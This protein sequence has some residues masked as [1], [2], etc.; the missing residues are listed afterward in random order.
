M[1]RLLSLLLLLALLALPGL[2]AHAQ[3]ADDSAMD[4]DEPDAVGMKA[5]Q[6]R[7]L[8]AQPLPDALPERYALLQQQVRAAEALDQRERQIAVLTELARLG[9]GMPGGETWVRSYLSAEFTWGSQ[10]K[11]LAACE[12]LLADKRISAPM[13]A[14]IAL[15]QTY[16]AALGSDRALMQ[17]HWS[18]ADRLSREQIKQLGADSVAGLRLQIERLQVQSEV[19]RWGGAQANSVALLRESVRVSERLLAGAKGNDEKFYAQKLLD[20]SLGML[21]YALV[22][23]GRSPEAVAIA[24]SNIAL[25]RSGQLSDAVGARW[26]YRLATGLV[27]TQAFDE[28]LKAARES[29]EMLERSGASLTSH[30]RWLARQQMLNALLG[31]HQ[32]AEADAL[33]QQTLAAVQDDSL[34]RE[35]ASDWRLRALLA[36]K[37]GRVDEA[38]E[39]VERIH[40]F[41]LR[42]YGANHPQTQEAAGVRGFV[43]L[44]RNDISGAMSDYEQLFKALLDSPGG[45]LDLDL[46][47]VRG[48]VLGLAL[49]QF[50]DTLAERSLAGQPVDPRM[51][52]RALQ[53]ADRLNVSSTQRALADST[54]RLLA[55]TPA[56]AELLANE[57]Q[58]RRQQGER[59]SELSSLLNEE[60]RQRREMGSDAF[61]AL[62]PKERDAA[63]AALKALREKIKSGQE[64][65]GNARSA[66]TAARERI[67]QAF[68]AYGDLLM[69]PT[70]TPAQLRSLLAPDE[71]LLLVHSLDHATLLWL[72]TPGQQQAALYVSKLGA[73]DLAKRVSQ[74]RRML[75]L[76]QPGAPKLNEALLL[77]LY[78]ELIAPLKPDYSQLHSLIVASSGALASLPLAALVTEPATGKEGAHYL[79]R[80]VA[81]TQ[82]PAASA[83]QSLRRGA[84]HIGAKPLI[85]FGDPAFRSAAASKGLSVTSTRYDAAWGFRYADIPPLPDTRTELMAL[86]QALGAKPADLLLGPAAT[87]EAVLK[88]PLADYRV[89]AFA[90]HGLMPGELPGVS[91]PALAMAATGREGESPLLELDDVLGLRLN[92]EWVLLSAC[93]TAAGEQGGAAM[94]GLVRGFFFAGARSVLA[95]HWSVDSAASSQLVPAALQPSKARAESLRQAQLAMI[96]GRVGQGRWTHPYYWAGYALFGDPLK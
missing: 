18:R 83:L 48:F 23:Q 35:R 76:S 29:D 80:S 16:F 15:R 31:L 64:Q 65:V 13:R 60:D 81:V 21:C 1:R 7:A 51:A 88:A 72:I 90:T 37:N 49:Q 19:E 4:A 39:T 46:R 52:D 58:L 62:P 77:G 67:A 17:G 68:P 44:M 92:A 28:G 87:R 40:R 74:T 57:Q 6:A 82:L 10:G 94:S 53:L 33:Y 25:W 24:Q 93:N 43:R 41:R 8:L 11:A 27:A 26:Q 95:T 96:E 30:T 56:L 20:G 12:T 75:D 71:G 63:R 3:S 36:A 61:K 34:A 5:E 78:R 38:L 91:K 69:P 54:A 50:M 59:A 9:L 2:P 45:W 86:A 70:P 66:L 42:L 22:R 73:A 84:A 85:G 79:A 89:A 32:W 55:A 14:T 47:G